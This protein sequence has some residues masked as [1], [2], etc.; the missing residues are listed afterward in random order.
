[1]VDPNEGNIS[2]ADE[3]VSVKDEVRSKSSSKSVKSKSSLT[4]ETKLLEQSRSN[5][6]IVSDYEELVIPIPSE[7]LPAEITED[8]E[9]KTNGG[10][11]SEPVIEISKPLSNGVND[12]HSFSD[13]NSCHSDKEN[14]SK[15][16]DNQKE[17]AVVA[18]NCKSVSEMLKI[19]KEK[20][21]VIPPKIGFS[22][23]KKFQSVSSEEGSDLIQ[24][25][26]PRNLSESSDG[27]PNKP[28]R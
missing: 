26:H 4:P 2:S 21:E 15:L 16:N 6:S 17:E 8:V 11:I 28:P 27:A 18:E 20:E 5:S 25:R 9:I 10:I 22:L 1:M 19:A 23:S 13:S 7:T 3:K 12:K 14:Q 24:G